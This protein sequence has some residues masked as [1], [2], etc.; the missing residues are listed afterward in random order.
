MIPHT[1]LPELWFGR[2]H[3]LALVP[4]TL[5]QST[6]GSHTEHLW[7]SPS[8]KQPLAV[9]SCDSKGLF[10]G[11]PYTGGIVRQTD[12]R[13]LREAQQRCSAI[14]LCVWPHP[15]S[16]CF[17]RDPSI[18]PRE[19]PHGFGSL[20]G[21][22][23]RTLSNVL[24]QTLCGCHIHDRNTYLAAASYQRSQRSGMWDLMLCI[25]AYIYI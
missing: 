15:G 9:L 11:L 3:F 24:M 8:G 13:R 1:T 14:L 10:L 16:S 20:V 21:Q 4:S 5:D 2:S 23:I 22:S 17:L 18:G 25:T 6:V 7:G 12:D 19:R